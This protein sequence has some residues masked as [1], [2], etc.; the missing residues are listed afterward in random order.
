MYRDSLS[1]HFPHNPVT[2]YNPR[3]A[4][5]CAFL[6]AQTALLSDLFGFVQDDIKAIHV[7]VLFCT[8]KQSLDGTAISQTHMYV[9]SFLVYLW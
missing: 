9:N 4:L 2:S 8:C 3:K 6:N 1:C 5:S 7:C